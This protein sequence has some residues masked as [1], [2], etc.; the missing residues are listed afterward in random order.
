M[1][2]GV[3]KLGTSVDDATGNFDLV[4]PVGVAQGDLMI[5]CVAWRGN[6]AITPPA[7]WTQVFTPQNS[8]DTDA[9]NG[10]ASGGM[11][12]IIR[13]ASAPSLTFTRTAGDVA[14]GRIISYSGAAS[15][16]L[17]HAAGNTLAVASAT[18]TAGAVTPSEEF[19]LIVAMT[20]AGD[21]YNVSAFDATDPAT[22]SGATDTTTAPTV[23]TWI[24]R[25]DVSTATGADGG[26][27]IADAI[28]STSGGTGIIQATV[29]GSA[30]HVMIA[31]A[32]K[33]LRTFNQ[34]EAAFYED[35]T[36]TGSV[37]IDSGADSITRDVTAGDSNLQLRIRIQE[38]SGVG[39][40]AAD[41][42]QLQYEIDDSGIWEDV[43]A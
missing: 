15:S 34:T 16:P 29:G 2:W 1:A 37:V 28:K 21:T 30:R 42:Y 13:G 18:A 43:A 3:P 19:D 22:A 11:W 5:A 40:S 39:G 20:S 7:G 36:E 10:I 24:E 25:S 14:L 4:E 12:Y 35:G 38:T 32:F 31:A 23:G 17:D 6:A 33:P 41:T 27:A 9:T 8:G 26:L